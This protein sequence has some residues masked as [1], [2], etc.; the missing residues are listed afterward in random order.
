MQEESEVNLVV[1]TLRQFLKDKL[2]TKEQLYQAVKDHKITL[3]E[4]TRTI[5]ILEQ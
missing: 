4:Y 5:S 1:S 2:L 3:E